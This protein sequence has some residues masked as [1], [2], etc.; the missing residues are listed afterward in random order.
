MRI[1]AIEAVLRSLLS[2]LTEQQAKKFTA[3]LEQTFSKIEKTQPLE[4]S[5][6]IEDVRQAAFDITSAALKS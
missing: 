4:V 3:N 5:Q 2:T 6:I 1:N